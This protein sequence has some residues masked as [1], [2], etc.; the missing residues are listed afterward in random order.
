MHMQNYLG[1]RVA[2]ANNLYKLRK[3][4]NMDYVIAAFRSV[5]SYLPNIVIMI[6]SSAEIR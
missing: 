6:Q 3:I 5:Y 1:F 4:V 2:I